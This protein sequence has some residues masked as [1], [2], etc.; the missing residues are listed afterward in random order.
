MQ[1]AHDVGGLRILGEERCC[2]GQAHRPGQGPLGAGVARELVRLQVANH[3]Q[4]M[5]EASQEPVRVGQDVRVGAPDEALIGQCLERAER[6]RLAEA[7]VAAAVDQLEE[8]HGELDV[9]DAAAAALQL[10][11]LLPGRTHV[12]LDARL[13]RAHVLD[14]AG[15]QNGREH[16]RGDVLD[17]RRADPRVTRD[18]ARLQQRLPLPGRCVLLVVVGHPL[19]RPGQRARAALGPEVGVDAE[20]DA[21]RAGRGEQVDHGGGRAPGPLHRRRAGLSMDEDHIDVGRV[22]Q[23]PAPELPHADDRELGAALNGRDGRLQTDLRDRRQLGHGLLDRRPFQVS[24]S[25][26]VGGP[27]AEPAEPVGGSQRGDVRGGLVRQPVL[28]PGRDVG[29][30]LHLVGV[31]HEEVG[32]RRGEPEQQEQRSTDLVALEQCAGD[33]TV[34]QAG[35]GDPGQLRIRGLGDACHEVDRKRTPRPARTRGGSRETGN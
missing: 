25:D 13:R 8:L 18:R 9:A 26:P 22:V 17:E 33:S 28:P 7:F 3:L 20:R 21:L 15:R 31:R 1:A 2:V 11:G 10:D 12:L 32:R 4:A 27:P 6:V 24:G 5:L 34:L 29:K 35:Q 16:Q 19:Q 30:R 14:G 23:L